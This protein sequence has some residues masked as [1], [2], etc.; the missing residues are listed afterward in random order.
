M[1]IASNHRLIIASLI[2]LTMSTT[3]S[4][5]A[6]NPGATIWV[7]PLI[8]GYGGVHPRPD[9]AAPPAALDYK[10]ITDLRH[11]S[12]DHTQ[13]GDSLERLARLANLLAYAGVPSAH[14][15][16]VAVIEGDAAFGAFT[17]DEYRR[18]FK[19]DNPNLEL[20]REL[21]R[22]G[23]ELMVCAQALAENDMPDSDVA[24][25]VTITLSALTD[26]AVYEAQGF[27]YLQL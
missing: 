4:V 1:S 10:L 8:K 14:V 17:N 19:T 16:I 5:G 6:D 25:E 27:G 18:R 26:F 3:S 9:L 15:H 23:I 21:K 2:L 13:P 22:S 24:P 20:L 12:A 7:H 11:G